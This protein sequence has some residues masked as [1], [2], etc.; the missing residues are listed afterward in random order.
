MMRFVFVGGEGG[1]GEGQKGHPCVATLFFLKSLF[2]AFSFTNLFVSSGTFIKVAKLGGLFFGGGEEKGR[3]KGQLCGNSAVV[4]LLLSLSLCSAAECDCP[5]WFSNGTWPG[6]YF[7]DGEE[8][9]E[10]EGCPE[11]EPGLSEEEAAAAAAAAAAAKTRVY[12]TDVVYECPAGGLG[13]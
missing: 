7:W 4:K 13:A 11:L 1:G 6:R 12:Q 5:P 3:T 8:L 2:Q 10:E 9:W